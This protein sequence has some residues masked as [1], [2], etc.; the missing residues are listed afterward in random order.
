MRIHGHVHLGIELPFVQPA[1]SLP[2]Q[3]PVPLRRAST[4]VAPVMS[5]SKSGSPI[6]ASNSRSQPP[7]SPRLQKRRWT[8][9]RP[10]QSGGRPR[11][12]D[13]ILRTQNT[14][15]TKRLSYSAMPP[16]CPIRPGSENPMMARAQSS[17]SRQQ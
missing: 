5:H 8:F 10:P 7:L 15:L 9:F 2:P 3:T 16:R 13:P 17:M 6:T 12:E 4:Y 1:P 11:Q 14:A